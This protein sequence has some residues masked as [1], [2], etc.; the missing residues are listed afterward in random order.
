MT[1]TARSR[2]GLAAALVLLLAST[3]SAAPTA[4]AT[5]STRERVWELGGRLSLAAIA[6]ANGAPAAAVN[7]V[8]Q[9]AQELGAGLG[10]EVPPLPERVLDKPKASADARAYLLRD[11]GAA[12]AGKLGAAYGADHS[13]LF[14]VAVKSNLLLLLY[15]PGDQ[16][17]TTIA[18]VIKRRSADARLPEEIWRDLVTKIEGRA[19]FDVVKNAVTKMHGDVRRLLGAE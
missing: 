19:T 13:A 17:S 15:L 16:D 4:Q 12:I 7:K 6:A 3:V 14:E 18:D 9:S 5:T 8:Y 10:V 1:I 11:A 2:T